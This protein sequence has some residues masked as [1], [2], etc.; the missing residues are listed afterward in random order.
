MI[1]IKNPTLVQQQ[2]LVPKTNV[3]NSERWKGA[4]DNDAWEKSEYH[5]HTYTSSDA[6]KKN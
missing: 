2:K 1:L 4:R 3:Q 6:E 5:T